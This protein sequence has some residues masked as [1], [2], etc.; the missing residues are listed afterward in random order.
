MQP[1]TRPDAR[2]VSRSSPAGAGQ[3]GLPR[4][5]GMSSPDSSGP[6]LE[7]DL[8]GNKD[9]NAYTEE[10]VGLLSQ[11]LVTWLSP[12]L[13]LGYRRPLQASDLPPLR[14]T[15]QA[16]NLGRTLSTTWAAR[17]SKAISRYSFIRAT[18][19]AYGG[20]FYAAGLLKLMGD[21]CGISSPMLMG[22]IV[23][24]LKM[25]G[26]LGMLSGVGLCF[27]IFALQMVNTLTVNTYFSITMQTGLR[28]RTATSTLLY[29]KALR[30]S[31]KA[32]QSFSTG[33]IVNLM[34]TDAGRMEMAVSYVHYIWSGPFQIIVILALLFRLLGWIAF[35]GFVFLLVGIP[36]QSRITTRLS[37]YRKE[38]AAT[39]DKRVRLMQEII[40]GIRVIKFYSWEV[41]F[42]GKLLDTRDQEVQRVRKASIIRS[43]TVVLT[44]VTAI[45]ACILTCLVYYWTGHQ[46]T[47]EIVFPTMALFTLLRLPLIL[48]PMVISMAVDGFVSAKRVQKF[49]LADELD[50]VPAV[51]EAAK[52]GIAVTKGNF[53]YEVA[54]DP[55]S[56]G[57]K[58]TA[59]PPRSTHAKAAL[60][61]EVPHNTTGGPEEPPTIA[62]FGLKNINFELPRGSLT[63]VVGSVGSG[64]SSLLN[65]LVGELKSQTGQVIF[66][67]RLAYCPQ[68]AWMQNGTV[69]E[70]IL[71][72]E[73]FDQ[74]QY[75]RVVAACALLPDFAMLPD[76]D[77]TE[78]GEK[79]VNLSGGQKQRISLAR[80][81]YS[82][83][84]IV[85]L[86]D[87]L[88]AV[89]A[90]VGR[91]LL[92]QCIN[93]IMKGRTRLLVTHQL[94]I[95]PEMDYILLLDQ[96]QIVES[97]T[98]S[99]L[100]TREDSQF[101][102]LMQEHA[103][104]VATPQRSASPSPSDGLD[105]VDGG[106]NGNGLQD[107]DT[108]S[109]AT[110]TGSDSADV[111]GAGD[112]S[113]SSC[114]VGVLPSPQ[115]VVV[116]A[117]EA[118][119]AL[120][121]SKTTEAMEQGCDS[122]VPSPLQ[123]ARPAGRITAA[124]DRAIGAVE[125]PIYKEY[126]GAA[127]GIRF[128]LV[129][130]GSVIAWNVT[131]VGTDLW[132]S[133]FVDSEASSWVSPTVF[134]SIYIGLGLLQLLFA[135]V[136]SFSVALGGVRAAST[137]H[138]NSARRILYAPVS[139]F[140]TNPTGRILNRFSKDQDTL[141]SLMPETTRS[142]MHTLG[143]TIFTLMTM[144]RVN[145]VL[146]LPLALLLA[147]YWY[148][149]SFYRHTSRELKRLESLS[150]SPLYAQFSETLTG[151]PTVRAFARQ[152]G[153]S[154]RNRQLLDRNNRAS[155]PQLA[156]QRWL[157][158]RLESVGNLIVLSSCLCCYL[159][160]VRPALAGLAI[161]YALSVTGVLN[162]C[163][164]QLA[165]AETQIISAERLGHYANKLAIEPPHETPAD[166]QPALAEWPQRGG[167]EFIN[168]TMS[169]R[170][171]LPSVLRGVTFSVAPG[172]R[173][174]IVG[175]TGAGKSSIMMA[176][177]RM[178]EA[179]EGAILIDGID[180]ATLGL[181]RLRSSIS[182]IPQ[183]PVVFAGTVR[184]NLDPF[185]EYTDQELW[186]TLEA[187][188]LRESI[189]HMEGGLD[190]LIHEGGEN[191][192]VGQRQLLCLAR[193]VLRKNRII[194]LDEATANIDL[195][196]DALIQAAIRRDFGGCTI[197]TIAHRVSTVIDYDR[198]LVLEQ[199]AIVEFDT[200]RALLDRADSHFASLVRE[201]G[202]Q[203]EALLR[204]H[205][206]NHHHGGNSS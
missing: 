34:S 141:D 26:K 180:I 29:G 123:P 167:I 19:D 185:R 52:A 158:V 9:D 206:S 40:Q 96:G 75:D 194:V 67:G 131:R 100:M 157:G 55:P 146:F 179:Q 22:Q 45:F 104:G 21:I 176:L 17:K 197:L 6:I 37:R 72:G 108:S 145:L 53:V 174:G 103:S 113:S 60:A 119:A 125:W 153:F 25:G 31:A 33:Q 99:E 93:G 128:A 65:A 102:N 106:Q 115:S 89:D 39:T 136:S 13:S 152:E 121:D 149:Q 192:S 18:L 165:D 184:W 114:Q 187:A 172:E 42:L 43:L 170:P 74:R 162:W 169:Y 198:I 166:M 105:G 95:M 143:L 178:T 200:P 79:G 30:L 127:G 135:I 177:F 139:F 97:G 155:V 58:R 4:M 78:I 73:P 173:I 199:G 110:E 88:S 117:Q 23:R 190:A 16:E 196:T 193:A 32:R 50:F 186:A 54:T 147:L 36:I 156:I 71:F 62:P 118:K 116:L 109:P 182:I 77:G 38:T 11:V 70:N 69:R 56:S 57:D 49:L 51:D 47:P 111:N 188:H 183:D 90:H 191:L 86:D 195:A 129:G 189:L 83:T 175:R 1:H 168:L 130:L 66:G 41:S 134:S 24:D 98:F 142:V 14:P 91:H 59:D 84:E 205:V 120:L 12:L 133:L 8:A 27:A 144:I 92:T 76:G 2:Y 82:R 160:S 137:L 150:R 181:R 15:F 81:A 154:T 10:N 28:I 7:D 202:E 164:R 5:S 101:A 63:A 107:T 161:T 46:L 203:N 87:P 171:D 85:L 201:T 68:Q 122:A 64:K 163:I 94:H 35:V 126:L 44:S 80:A 3:R 140:D 48:L 132:I 151:L 20:P 138:D 124:E 112:S 204:S 159:F 148:I 61:G